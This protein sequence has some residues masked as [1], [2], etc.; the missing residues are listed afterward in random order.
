MTSETTRAIEMAFESAPRCARL[1]DRLHVRVH[2]FLEN[3]S[4][5]E[6]VD[7]EAWRVACHFSRNLRVSRRSRRFADA[8][9]LKKVCK[10]L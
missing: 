7:V 4:D 6:L 9:D 1:E 8:L 3:A 10:T 2:R 5:P